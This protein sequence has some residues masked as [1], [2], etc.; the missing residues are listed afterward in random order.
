MDLDRR[1]T[2]KK[3][4]GGDTW[5]RLTDAKKG[6]GTRKPGRMVVVPRIWWEAPPWRKGNLDKSGDAD[7]VTGLDGS[8]VQDNSHQKGEQSSKGGK[9]GRCP[10]T[11]RG[12]PNRKNRGT[13]PFLLALGKE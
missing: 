13:K 1:I 2:N 10:L 12:E 9:S 5:P 4:T 7:E 11:A 3:R 6:E 8:E